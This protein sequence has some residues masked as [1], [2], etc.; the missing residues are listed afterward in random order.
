MENP[1]EVIGRC[2]EDD[3]TEWPRRKDKSWM[4]K[5][6]KQLCQME[7][8]LIKQMAIYGIQRWVVYFE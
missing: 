3:N 2:D 8:N 7:I 1:S 4:L 6:Q 5:K